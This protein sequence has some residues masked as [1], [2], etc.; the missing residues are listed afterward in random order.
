MAYFRHERKA[1]H[2]LGGES[3]LGYCVWAG[4]GGAHLGLVQRLSL[5]LALLCDQLILGPHRIDDAVE[6]QG[7]VIVHGQDDI[8]VCDVGLHLRQLL[9]GVEHR[10]I[11]STRLLGTSVSLCRPLKAPWGSQKPGSDRSPKF[12][13]YC[14]APLG[15]FTEG[16]GTRP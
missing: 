12:L 5:F 14:Y 10:L 4:G 2:I 7:A 6:I 9:Q 15:T 13:N 1:I 3:G 8:G 16:K 11:P